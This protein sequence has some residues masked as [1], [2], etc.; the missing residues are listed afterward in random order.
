MKTSFAIITMTGITLNIIIS[1]LLQETKFV[2]MGWILYIW[3]HRTACRTDSKFTLGIL[4]TPVK[5]G[6]VCSSTCAARMVLFCSTGLIIMIMFIIIM[7]L[8]DQIVMRME[9]MTNYYFLSHG[10]KRL[11]MS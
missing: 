2:L 11:I 5:E 6:K 9:G 4:L 8:T 7:T 1:Y 10:T 3:F